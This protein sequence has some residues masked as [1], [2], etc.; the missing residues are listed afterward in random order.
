MKQ[1]LLWLAFLGAN[2][3]FV[4]AQTGMP[5]QSGLYARLDTVAVIRDNPGLY[6]IVISRDDHIIYN[7]MF[8]GTGKDDLFNDQSL[9][10]SICSLLIGIAIDKGYIPSV[11]EKIV[12][13]FPEL[14]NDSDARKRTITLEELMDQASGLYHEQ[15][16]TMMGIPDFLALPDPS[17]Y[18]LHAPMAGDPGKEWHYNNA[19]THLLSLILTRSTGMSTLDF[20]EQHLFHPLGID[21][22]VWVKMKDGYYDGSGLLSIRLRTRDLVK[23]GSLL[24]QEGR[25]EG[26]TIVSKKWIT[27]L[28]HPSAPYTADWGFPA[29]RYA[30]CWYHTEIGE[31][32]PTEGAQGGAGAAGMEMTY[33]MGWGG[34]FILVIPALRTVIAVNE[35]TADAT[36]VKQSILF[37]S[38][39][40]PALL[41][42]IS[43]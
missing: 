40:F 13:W 5:G 21:S 10:K 19:A 29:S 9:T 11:K 1:L 23:I 27:Q 4:F 32:A 24:L 41:R 2:G 25:Y 30:F 16:G 14:N 39:I 37:T 20:A 17:G 43:F 36:A 42:A 18:T 31:G 33:G 8:N 28:L 12:R 22:V 34:Q 38:R 35:R 26:R 15:L 7:K 3:N 6:S